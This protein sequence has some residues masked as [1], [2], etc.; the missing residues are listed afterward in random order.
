MPFI[1]YFTPNCKI[2]FFSEHIKH[3]PRGAP[4]WLRWL[5]FCLPLRS[6]SPGPGLEPYVRLLAQWG[7]SFSLCLSPPAPAV[8][9]SLSLSNE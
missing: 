7:V 4:G 5:S 9:F 2:Y 6:L 8:S 3:W 1:G